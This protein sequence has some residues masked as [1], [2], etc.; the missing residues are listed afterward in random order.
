MSYAASKAHPKSAFQIRNREM[1]DR[2]DLVICYIENK[3]GGAW[4]TIKYAMKKE[5]NIINLAEDM[6]I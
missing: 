1:V 4:Q 5:K 2:A 6:N 3:E